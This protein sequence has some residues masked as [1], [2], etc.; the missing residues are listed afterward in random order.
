MTE[1]CDDERGEDLVSLNRRLLIAKNPKRKLNFSETSIEDRRKTGV[2]I[3]NVKKHITNENVIRGDNRHRLDFAKK[4]VNP[5]VYP[6]LNGSDISELEGVQENDIQKPNH[7][8]ENI[9]RG[10]NVLEGYQSEKQEI[11]TP[12]PKGIVGDSIPSPKQRNYFVRQVQNYLSLVRN[13]KVKEK[14]SILLKYLQNSPTSHELSLNDRGEVQR[15]LFDT[16]IKFSEYLNYYVASADNEKRVKRPAFYD[17]IIEDPLNEYSKVGGRF[18][19]QSS[20]ER[21]EYKSNTK[22]NGTTQL[23]DI[24]NDD[25]RLQI[26]LPKLV[27]LLET[28]NV[29]TVSNEELDEDDYEDLINIIAFPIY[30]TSTQYPTLSSFKSKEM[31]YRD[32]TDDLK[33]LLMENYHKYDSLYKKEGNL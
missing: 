20:T 32:F 15:G 17:V 30:A 3:D 27:N 14:L 23:R 28:L 4:A 9:N 21:V 11:N 5:V 7:I 10:N 2:D 1:P 13:P 29:N 16:Q 25:L 12:L 6:E 33:S 26:T 24:K 8:E 31:E 22:K 18:H 19:G